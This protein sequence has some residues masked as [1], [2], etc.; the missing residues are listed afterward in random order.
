L[1]GAIAQVLDQRLGSKANYR[2]KKQHVIATT[3]MLCSTLHS[4][5]WHDAAGTLSEKSFE[6]IRHALSD[7]IVDG[8]RR[9]SST[10]D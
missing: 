2:H 3:F 6:L 8:F 1:G 9:T 7:V 5:R 4:D 10:A